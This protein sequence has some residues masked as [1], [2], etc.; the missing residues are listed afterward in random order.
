MSVQNPTIPTPT[1]AKG[2]DAVILTA[3]LQQLQTMTK[4][5][6]VYSLQILALFL[7]SN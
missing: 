4:K 3:T 6:K 7:T 2:V 5:D 1:Q